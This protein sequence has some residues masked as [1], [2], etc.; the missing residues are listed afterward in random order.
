M[1]TNTYDANNNH[2]SQLVQY[3][4][5]SAWDND[6]KYTNTYDA[7]NNLTSQLGQTWNGSAWDN[8]HKFTLTYD[9]NNNQ[10][11]ILH[12]TWNGSAWVNYYKST[13]I[14]DAN[15]NK[16]S[17]LHQYWNGSAWVN[18]SKYTYNYDANNFL[19]SDTY[20][21]WEATGTTI[22]NGD[23]S[24]YYFHTVVGIN[25]LTA[26]QGS[27]SVYPNPSIDDIFIDGLTGNGVVAIYNML[28][29]KIMSREF[30]AALMPLKLNIKNI[31]KGIYIVRANDDERER[32]VKMIKQ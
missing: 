29:E 8:D 10:T 25:N 21:E 5:G 26:Q 15:N 32:V 4:N 13:N 2:T 6:N 31:A 30:N 20:I 16:T 28:G 7:N 24:Y 17:Q 1:H 12:Q 27:I 19:T 14:Y 23:S 9:A 3:W 11:N 22:T 18:S